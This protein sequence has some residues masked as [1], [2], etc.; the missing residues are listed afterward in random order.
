MKNLAI[1]WGPYQV[2]SNSIVPGPIAGT[3]GMRRL[4]PQDGAL[5]AVLVMRFAI[6]LFHCFVRPRL[7]IAHLLNTI[8]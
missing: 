8:Q 5:A 6:P 7:K 4:A 3:E 1:E 2:R